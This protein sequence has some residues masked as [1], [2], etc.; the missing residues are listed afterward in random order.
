MPNSASINC[1]YTYK[2][3]DETLKVAQLKEI[4]GSWSTA[5]WTLV[6]SVPR[7]PRRPTMSWGASSTALP[8][9]QGKGLF[10]SALCCATSLWALCALLDATEQKSHKTLRGC[11]EEGYK[12]DKRSG[13]EDIW[14]GVE[15]LG[16]FSL[17]R[18]ILRRDFI[19]VCG[20]LMPGSR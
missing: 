11:L 2:I 5:R 10:C 18:G 1:S 13:G 9:E 7:Q 16:L 20:L 19:T 4:W 8:T 14:G 6:T 17:G 3:G 15:D 12:N